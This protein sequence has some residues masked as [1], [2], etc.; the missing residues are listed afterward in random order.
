MRELGPLPPAGRR[1]SLPLPLPAPSPPPAAAS[2]T[3]PGAAPA[4]ELNPAAATSCVLV[5]TLVSGS[6]WA[7]SLRLRQLL[8]RVAAVLGGGADDGGGGDAAA[9]AA[10]CARLSQLWWGARMEGVRARVARGEAPGLR[11]CEGCFI[12]QSA[13]STAVDPED[14]RRDAAW[15]ARRVPTAAPG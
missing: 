3:G 10:V 15:A 4:D 6:T 9:T 5:V 12:P 7:L 11:A 13:N 1:L 14:M 2:C 8:A